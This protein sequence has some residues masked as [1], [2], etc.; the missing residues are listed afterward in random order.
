MVSLQVC[1]LVPVIRVMATSSASI[2]ER[3]GVGRSKLAPAPA[4]CRSFLAAE[5]VH[6]QHHAGEPCLHRCCGRGAVLCRSCMVEAGHPARPAQVCLSSGARRGGTKD[7]VACD[8]A[9]ASALSG[10]LRPADH[11][12]AC[13]RIPALTH[14]SSSSGQHGRA[15]LSRG[16]AEQ[17]GD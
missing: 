3:F 4:V 10:D 9:A 2:N 14:S 11:A 15:P 8:T 16:G 7:T 5:I 1:T 13:R 17:G 12:V 6:T